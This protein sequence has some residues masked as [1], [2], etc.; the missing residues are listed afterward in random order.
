MLNSRGFIHIPQLEM[1]NSVTIWILISQ[2]WAQ[3][4]T[5]AY[6]HFSLPKEKPISFYPEGSVVC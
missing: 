2:L 3:F 1:D 6:T 5:H 4:V